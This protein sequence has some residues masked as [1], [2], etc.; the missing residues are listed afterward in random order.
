MIPQMAEMAAG[1][2]RQDEKEMSGIGM[3]SLASGHE[4][5]ERPAVKRPS[6]LKRKGLWR[7]GCGHEACS[8]E[9]S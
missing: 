6:A 1:R 4:R 7:I 5:P 3:E 9:R 2:M 8:E